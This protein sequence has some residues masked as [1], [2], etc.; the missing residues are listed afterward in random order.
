MHAAIAAVDP[1]PG[2]EIITTS[3]TDMGALRPILYQGAIPVFADVDPATGNVTAAT[4]A[5]RLS[6]RT[7]AIVVDPP[8]RQSVR[9]AAILALADAHGI[10]VIEDCA[11]AFL[12]RSQG[13]LVGTDRRDR[14]LQHAAGQ[15]HHHR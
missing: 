8:L 6:D 5:D 12:A 15:A 13:E 10:P 3:I 7:R 1:E 2:D 4:I 9:S 14:L 11:Q